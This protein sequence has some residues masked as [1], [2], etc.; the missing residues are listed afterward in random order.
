MNAV[1]GYSRSTLKNT[2]NSDLSK[3]SNENSN[4]SFKSDSDINDQ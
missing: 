1:N 4:D 2:N 3:D